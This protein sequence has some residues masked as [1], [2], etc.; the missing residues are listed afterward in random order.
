MTII[1][2]AL[3]SVSDK[4]EIVDF[5]TALQRFGIEI[6]STGGTAKLLSEAGVAVTE[7]SDYTGFPE[8]LDGRVKTLHPKVHA[9]ILARRDLEEHTAAMEKAGFGNIDLV[10]VNLYPFTQTIAK[11]DCTLEDAIENIDIGGP[12]MVRA[13]AKNYAHV[14]IV[15]DPADYAPLLTEMSSSN[16]AIG[17]ETRFTLAKKAFTHTAAYDG[18]ISNY[19]T[20]LDTQQ[21]RQTFPQSL[22]MQFAKVQDLRY[23]ENPHQMGAFYRDNA[24]VPGSISSYTQ[25]MGKELSYN[26]IADSDAAWECVKTFDGPACVIIKHANPCGVAV[27][28][29]IFDA[30]KL[31]FATDPTSAFGGIIAFNRELDR[32]TAEAVIQ[33]FVEVVIAPGVS[34]E[35]ADVFAQKPNIRLLSVALD[36]GSNNFDYKRVGGGLLVQTPD[37]LNVGAADLRVVTKVQP[38]A[39]QLD[40]LLFAWRVAKFVKSNAIVFAAKGQTLGVG[41]GQMSRV[42]ST[43][44]AAIK[45]QNAGL[46]LAGA[47]VASDA[48][49]PFRDGVDVLAAAGAKAVIQPGGSIRDDDVVAAADEHGIAMVLTGARH[50]RH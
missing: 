11:P 5:A 18:A 32:T 42:D 41:A 28:G 21:V 49:F 48:F 10:V 38:T 40:D 3:I 15:T 33:Q 16:G 23:G 8:M 22:S 30:Y 4:T 47:A 7:V 26:N 14:A 37:I 24:A 45:A 12:T 50:F 39:E 36:T 25:L 6:L 1:K 9:G 44:I 27:A 13:A 17:A 29:N 46:S 31:A 2:R 35:A 43:R 19:L 34:A 20:S